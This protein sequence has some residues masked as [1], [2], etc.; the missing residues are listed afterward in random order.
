MCVVV[1]IG[2]DIRPRSSS[3]PHL[4]DLA[5]RLVSSFSPRIYR[6]FAFVD[7]FFPKNT[8]LTFSHFDVF[9]HSFRLERISTS[10]NLDTGSF[11]YKASDRILNII[12]ESPFSSLVC[13]IRVTITISSSS[14]LNQRHSAVFRRVF[15]FFYSFEN[16]RS[17]LLLLEVY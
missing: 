6:A 13:S 17:P 10:L 8:L 11:V 9:P 15:A 2:A 3:V 7:S 16:R 4:P 1:T 12:V 5:F 14:A